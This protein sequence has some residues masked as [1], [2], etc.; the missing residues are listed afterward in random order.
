MPVVQCVASY[1][2]NS[3]TLNREDNVTIGDLN[4][5]NNTLKLE[6]T[7]TLGQLFFQQVL[8]L[9]TNIINNNAITSSGSNLLVKD[10]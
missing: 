5:G 8:L 3:W 7:T 6:N 10:I 9:L 4:T 1:T 2:C